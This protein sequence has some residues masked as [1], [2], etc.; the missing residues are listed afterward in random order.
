M[1]GILVGLAL[2]AVIAFVAML[3][4]LTWIVVMTDDVTWT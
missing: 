3:V 1:R 2:Y 4:L